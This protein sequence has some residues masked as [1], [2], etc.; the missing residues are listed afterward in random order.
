MT[1]YV[2]VQTGP[3]FLALLGILFIGLKLCGVIGWSWLWVLCPLWLPFAV[4]LGAV[5]IGLIVYLLVILTSL[6]MVFL[7]ERDFR[8]KQHRARK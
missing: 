6:L 5:V 2:A 7:S 1:K 3:S 8:R 4:A